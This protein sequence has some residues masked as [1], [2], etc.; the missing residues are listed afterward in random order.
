MSSDV[1]KIQNY[2]IIRKLS[3]SSA[4]VYLVERDGIEYAL[5]ILKSADSDAVTRFRRE[6]ATLAR[7]KHENLVKLF[8]IGESDEGPFLVM[9]F[10]RGFTIEEYLKTNKYSNEL[11]LETVISIVKALS[12]LHSNNLVHRDVKPSNVFIE[13]TG[14]IKLIDLGLVGDVE[15]IKEEKSLVG[16]PLFCSPEQSRILKAPRTCIH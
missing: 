7:I 15:Q 8:D 16:T 2:R 14:A 11:A 13:Q 1:S 5:K 9:E 3:E 4:F 12:E 10:L 6:S